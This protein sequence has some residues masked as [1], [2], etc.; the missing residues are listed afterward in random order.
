MRLAK[1]SML[2]LALAA[3]QACDSQSEQQTDAVQ[4]VAEQG[5]DPAAPAGG[6]ALTALGLTEAEML[7]AD[8]VTAD[9]TDLGD[10]EQLRRNSNGAVDGVLVSIENTD[11]PR[12]VMVPTPVL[13]TRKDGDDTNLQTLMSAADLAAL[14]DAQLDA[15]APAASTTAAPAGR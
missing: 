11:P 6:G 1:L 15:D 3:L 7:D 9:G 10:V 4:N 8:L 2:P 14:P 12:Y 5:P 13:T